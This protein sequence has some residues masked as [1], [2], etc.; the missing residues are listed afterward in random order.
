MSEQFTVSGQ[1]SAPPDAVWAVLADYFRLATWASQIDHSSAMT[2]APA[3][4]GASRRVA[5]G[6]SVL[7]EN[8]VDWK[9]SSA[10][11]YEIVG[12][13][14]IVSRVE[15]RWELRSTGA[16]TSI[17]LTCSVEPGPKPPMKVAAKAV[18]RRIGKVNESL[19]ADLIAA[20]EE[21]S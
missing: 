2:A 14:P 3:G 12:L 10:M 20:A 18:V 11:A 7:I 15:N 17:T 5:T 16:A 13:P 4:M 6:G 21:A 8:V 1:T 19:V 9:P